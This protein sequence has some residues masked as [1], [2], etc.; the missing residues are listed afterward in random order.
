MGEVWYEVEREEAWRRIIDLCRRL[1]QRLRVLQYLPPEWREELARAFEELLHRFPEEGEYGIA[2]LSADL[3]YS[4][5]PVKELPRLI[6][7]DPRV[8]RLIVEVLGSE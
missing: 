8:A 1:R 3:P 5:I 2:V 4:V 6:R 7:E